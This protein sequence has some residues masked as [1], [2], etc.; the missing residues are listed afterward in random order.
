SYRRRA[1]YPG[2]PAAPGPATDRGEAGRG[3]TF[4]P[5]RWAV[6]AGVSGSLPA[7]RGRRLRA[8]L[9]GGRATGGPARLAAS[10]VGP[11]QPAGARGRIVP[12]R[13]VRRGADPVPASGGSLADRAGGAGGTSE[14]CA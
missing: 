10:A 8:V 12:E 2:G 13:Q 4:F 11:A 5:G 1:E 9:A 7:D 3:S 14:G 6:A